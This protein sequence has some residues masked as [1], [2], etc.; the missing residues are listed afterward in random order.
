LL[1]VGLAFGGRTLTLVAP[2]DFSPAPA[3]RA[4]A[5]RRGR[6]IVRVPI[7]SFSNAHVARVRAIEM[8]PGRV[9][10]EDGRIVYDGQPGDVLGES[11]DAYRELVPEA[12]RRYLW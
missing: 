12:W 3:I 7:T 1:R 11:E 8:V 5:A 10:G 9:Q 2:D 4:D 6:T